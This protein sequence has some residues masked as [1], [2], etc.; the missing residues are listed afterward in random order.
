[1]PEQDQTRREAAGATPAG[2]GALRVSHEDRDQVAEALRVAAGDG[3]LT[4]DEL[5]KDVYRDDKVELTEW[6]REQIIVELPAHPAH[7]SCEPPRSPDAD[8]PRR[9]PRWAALEKLK[10][11]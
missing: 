4:A 1:M 9:D 8:T 11:K 3:R 6:V 7:E 10:T 2:R 5:D